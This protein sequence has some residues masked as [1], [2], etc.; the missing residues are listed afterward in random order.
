MRG[1]HARQ[2][3]AA[4]FFQGTLTQKVVVY[5]T[6]IAVLPLA[7][8]GALA[9]HLSRAAMLERVIQD[10]RALLREKN[11]SLTLVM[12]DVNSLLT[13]LA[14]LDDL[15][16]ALL[17]HHGAALPEGAYERLATQAKIGYILSGYA[18]LSNILSIDLFS[19]G[20]AHYHVGETLDA[21]EIRRAL[22]ARLFRD[23]SASSEPVYWAGIEDNITV[24][25]RSPKVITALKV[26]R[27]LNTDTATEE[28]IGLLV[29]S[30]S[31]ETFYK[32]FQSNV[33][34]GQ[35]FRLVDRALRLIYHTDPSRVGAHVQPDVETGLQRA[36]ETFQ[37]RRDNGI[38]LVMKLLD[39]TTGWILLTTIPI[40]EIEAS[41]SAIGRNTLIAIALSIILAGL[42]IGQMWRRVTRPITTIT[43]HFRAIQDGEPV[44]EM[45]LP[46]RSNDE[47]GRLAQWFNAFLESLIERHKIEA[48][49]RESQDQLRRSHGALERRVKERTADLRQANDA[50]RSEMAEHRRADEDRLALQEQLR[51]SQKMEAIGQLAG[52]VA[53]DFNNLLTVISGYAQILLKR[54]TGQ[55][56]ERDKVAE[57][58]K[59]AQQAATLT[60][61]LLAFSR[62]QVLQ[63]RV[64]DIDSRVRGLENM[65]RRLIGE[66][67]ELTTRRPGPPGWVK[68]DP[69]QIEQ[70]IVN[71][72]VNARDAMPHG[73]RVIIETGRV[74]VTDAMTQALALPE[75]A[76][77]T[78]TVEDSGEGIPPEIRSQIFEPFF[79]TKTQGKGT[80]LGLSTVYGI[81]SQSGGH[82]RVESQV[83]EGTRFTMYLPAAEPSPIADL[84]AHPAAALRRGSE[85]VLIVEDAESVR[86]F[87]GTILA[88]RGYTV[89]EAETAHQA[90]RLLEQSAQTS[91]D[92]VLS[93]IVMPGMNGIE[94]RRLLAEAHPEVSVILMSGYADR[95]LLQDVGL[96]FPEPFI[97]KPFTPEQLLR[98]VQTTL[99]ARTSS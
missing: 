63:P 78:L 91:F 40:P 96:A 86:R 26:I 76:Y 42:F 34:R 20:A 27:H 75:G 43:Q 74:L 55:E 88:E 61:Q 59:A 45:R 72:V 1:L 29:I 77:V 73:G 37:I 79:T 5:L 80:G 94:M 12:H 23:A 56:R 54:L 6:L 68:A 36:D 13:S 82:V 83:G 89:V 28:P 2:R 62:K 51:Q 85:R 60:Q 18:N 99:D 87:A 25:S 97:Q 19:M 70:V 57:I 95:S 32:Y 21:T 48:A 92:V 35:E 10:H 71:L 52:G 69:G 47:M 93:D 58:Q 53:H 38:N 3:G 30:Y 67:V 84:S 17:Q 24:S 15:Q 31:P 81:I 7:V 8:L 16:Q 4:T 50:L 11:N 64:L 14:G 46:I 66:N 44:P 33:P 90:L 39:P 98:A 65:L 49:L 22:L 9:F 41:L